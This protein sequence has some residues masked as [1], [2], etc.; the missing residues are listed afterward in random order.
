M[1]MRMRMRHAACDASVKDDRCKQTGLALGLLCLL[2]GRA[3]AAGDLL[4]LLPSKLCP[5]EE[6]EEEKIAQFTTGCAHVFSLTLSLSFSLVWPLS[7]G[8]AVFAL[9]CTAKIMFWSTDK[10]AV[11]EKKEMKT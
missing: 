10:C 4:L 9:G 5:E 8:Y 3:D 2:S 7:L 1:R 11:S 6:E